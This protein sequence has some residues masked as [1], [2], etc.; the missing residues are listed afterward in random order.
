MAREGA[1]PDPEGTCE[2]MELKEKSCATD[3]F[4]FSSSSKCKSQSGEKS[5]KERKTATRFGRENVSTNYSSS[6]SKDLCIIL[7]YKDII[8]D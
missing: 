2:N 7:Q 3:K 5:D 1:R 6:V 4:K 8:Q